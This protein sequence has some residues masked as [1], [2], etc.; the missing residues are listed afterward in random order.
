[1]VLESIL[2]AHVAENKYRYV[3]IMGLVIT[4][5]AGVLASAIGSNNIL[6]SSLLFITF[7]SIPSVPLMYGIIKLEED[8]TM[9]YKSEWNVLNEHSKALGAFM[10]L[11]FGFVVGTLALFV[12]VPGSVITDL[13]LSQIRQL[14]NMGHSIFTGFVFESSIQNFN[15]IFF[16]NLKV[17]IL[18]TV[19]SFFFG[20]G[21][22]F[23]L[24]WNA[25]I[26]GTAIGSYIKQGLVRAAEYSGFQKI[27]ELSQVWLTGL[28]M[29]SIHGIPEI[30]AYF[31]AGLAGGVIS[32]A[33]A[34]HHYKSYKF[35]KVIFDAAD[36]L[37]I[38][39]GL[40]LLAA[41]LEVWV[42][43]LIF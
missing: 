21:A 7:I 34:R 5:I 17:L 38:S 24:A 35:E 19:F 1:M 39:I 3:F 8:K 26:I 31:T 36:L 22:I 30:L 10:F 37:L 11:F 43:P 20:A 27:T 28:F 15:Y 29:F 25:S 2:T 40:L 41:V 33:V 4:L 9:K 13:F 32:I 42:T 23:I 12:F 16:N 14:E 18:A 6:D